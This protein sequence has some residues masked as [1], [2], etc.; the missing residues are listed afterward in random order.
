MKL[1]TPSRRQLLLG[2]AAVG[3]LGLA[4]GGYLLSAGPADFFRAM[5]DARLP[6]VK[7]SRESI[8]AFVEDSL[9]NRNDDFLPKLKILSAGTRAVGYE[10][11]AAAMKDNEAFEVFDREFLTRFLLGSNFFNVADP[12]KEEVIFVGVPPACGN[13]FARFE[14]PQ[15]A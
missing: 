11:L 15:A 14:P 4:G 10:N 7:I 5:L 12:T 2:G 9:K 3:A 13:P 1:T 6:G 8:E